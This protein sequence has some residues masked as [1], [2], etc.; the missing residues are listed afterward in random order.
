MEKSKIIENLFYYIVTFSYLLFPVCL[1]FLGNRK[2]DVMPLILTVYGL[3]CCSFLYFYDD[4]PKETKPYFQTFYTFFEYCVFTSFFWI[5][6]KNK[7]VKQLI[8]VSS[9]LFFVFQILY[10]T[11]G[12]VKGLDS[13]PIGVETILILLYIIY[14]FY[15][16]SK[17]S[18]DIYLYNH[19]VFW[20]AVGILI[21]L[22]GSFFFF[23]L[24]QNLS[25][26]QVSAFENLTYIAE[27]IKNILF[28]LA[29]IIY[30]RHPFDKTPK[31]KPESVPFLDMI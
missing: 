4:F 23:I 2:K 25:K 10:M 16:F 12:K 24:F 30:V 31:N 18:A 8:L 22:G 5:S 14:Y 26:E 15:K 27:I 11:M 7:K 29:M 9:G 1:L 20:I 3:V 28:A 21:Y 19:Y 17:D 6:I 13:F